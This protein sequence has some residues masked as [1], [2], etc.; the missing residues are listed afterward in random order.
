MII[1]IIMI[2]NFIY[3]FNSI[4]NGGVRIG[5]PCIIIRTPYIPLYKL[6]IIDETII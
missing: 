5:T 6:Y 1:N 3:Y 2:L 4:Y